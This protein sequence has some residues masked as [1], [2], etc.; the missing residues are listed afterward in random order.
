MGSPARWRRSPARCGRRLI[1]V[2]DA[3]Q[4]TL[5]ATTDLTFTEGPSAG[6][7]KRAAWHVQRIDGMT[8]DAVRRGAAV[9]ARRRSPSLIV[10]R[11]HIGY[12]SPKK[13]DTFG[14]HGEPLGKDEVLATK[15]A[16]DGRRMPNV[17]V[18][19][20]ARPATARVDEA[21]RR[22][23]RG[24]IASTRIARRT[25]TSP[26]PSRWRWPAG[27]R[28]DGKSVCP[29]S[30]PRTARWPRAMPAAKC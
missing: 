9:R 10:A 26:T 11:T 24:S 28:R 3:N 25:P 19:D 22:K 8:S 17:H 21:A 20:E 7:S 6:A 27:C 2:Y 4:V 15:R 1:V 5:S 13:Q 23:P 16:L 14:A 18:P 30:R 12:G 29:R